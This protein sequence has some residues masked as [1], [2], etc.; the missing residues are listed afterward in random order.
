MKGMV[1]KM[2]EII[3]ILFLPEDQNVYWSFKKTPSIS[4]PKKETQIHEVQKKNTT[5]SVYSSEIKKEQIKSITQVD[6]TSKNY[7]EENSIKDKEIYK[8]VTRL[9][10]CMELIAQIKCASKLDT[11]ELDKALIL[12]E[13]LMRSLK[14]YGAEKYDS[15]FVR[16]EMEAASDE[17][18][19]CRSTFHFKNKTENEKNDNERII[20]EIIEGLNKKRNELVIIITNL[21]DR[22]LLEKYEPTIREIKKL[23][24]ELK[25]YQ[26]EVVGEYNVSD[27]YK[28]SEKFLVTANEKYQVFQTEEKK[29]NEVPAFDFAAILD[30]FENGNKQKKK[31]NNS[32]STKKQE[33]PKDIVSSIDRMKKQSKKGVKDAT[34]EHFT[35]GDF[36]N[37][38]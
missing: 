20:K 4:S 28:R 17:I 12:A 10:Q 36:L 22:S 16:K 35:I 19:F 25:S 11:V 34:A 33:N 37:L 27:E 29:R 7:Q 18:R 5:K 26:S 24:E 21:K 15:L 6:I 31:P 1:D 23:L 8:N 2:S 38:K 13:S 32:A 30:K 14:D 9:H 3:E